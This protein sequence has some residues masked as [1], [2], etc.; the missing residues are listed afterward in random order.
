MLALGVVIACA[1]TGRGEGL[2]R[3]ALL[4]SVAAQLGDHFRLEGDV[5][6]ELQRP[7]VDLASA[8]NEAWTITVEDFPGVLT[9]SLVLRVRLAQG[10]RRVR[11]ESLVLR[12]Q[13]WQEAFVA[14]G[15]LERGATLDPRQLDR[16]RVDVLRERDVVTPMALSGADYMLAR[17]VAAGRAVVWR[18]LVRR[19]LVRK[20]DVIE[21]SAS[22]G[23][24]AITMKALAMENGAVGET[25]RVRNLE[26][27][28]EFSAL[29]TAPARAEVRF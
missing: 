11:E 8:T 28:R 3:E 16:R 1:S 7:W 22:D 5:Q 27:R 6:L 4:G 26:S 2:T 24:L 29:V 17:P 19:A 12:A 10:D 25:V 23:A 21:V 15:P 18:D 20:G 13:L 14:T 9:S